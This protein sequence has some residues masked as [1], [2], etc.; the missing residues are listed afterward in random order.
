LEGRGSGC[1]I[2]RSGGTPRRS[3]VPAEA[4]RIRS[5]ASAQARIGSSCRSKTTPSKVTSSR[6]IA[7]TN[8]SRAVLEKVR[9]S[10][11]DMP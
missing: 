4:R 9:L 10:F 7:R 11:G 3:R 6:C 1:G 2:I 5:S 8:R